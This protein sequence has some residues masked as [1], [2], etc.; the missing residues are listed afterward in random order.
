LQEAFVLQSASLN[1]T[2]MG[3]TKAAAFTPFL[4]TSRRESL[5]SS[6]MVK[7]LS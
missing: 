2:I 1:V 4:S 3:T 6:D 7:F 5:I